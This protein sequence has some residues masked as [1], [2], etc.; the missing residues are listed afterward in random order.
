MKTLAN[1]TLS[2]IVLL[3][4]I[5]SIPVVSGAQPIKVGVSI[6]APWK[7]EKD[8]QLEGAGYEMFQEI[9]RRLE[10]DVEYIDMPFKRALTYMQSGE[11]DMMFGL[12]KSPEREKFIH[13]IA[14]PYK[15]KSNKAFY[16]LKGKNSQINSHSDLYALKV[17]VKIGV[18]YFPE[19]DDDHSIQK[20]AEADYEK[21]ISKLLLG[22]ID[23]FLC[24]DSHADYLIKALG[25]EK[26]IIKAKYGYTK[27]N[28]TYIGI[29]KKSRMLESKDEVQKVV[30]EM[31]YSGEVDRIFKAYFSRNNLA[32][33]DYK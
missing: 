21:N 5:F 25:V 16:I 4:G 14:P 28:P 31:V 9:V 3:V 10:L 12:L 11:I 26:S 24:T 22:A 23:T 27:N 8:G 15:L 7:F 33:P 2:W 29:S 19:F 18:K 1:I 13:F 6:V 17:G 32:I 20:Y 30:A